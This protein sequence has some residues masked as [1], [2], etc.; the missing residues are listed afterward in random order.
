MSFLEPILRLLGAE[1][2]LF[3]L[4]RQYAIPLLILFPL[5]MF[6]M[7]FQISFITVGKAHLGFVVS[8]LGGITNIVLDYLLIAVFDMGV[9]GAAIATSIGYSIPSLSML[10]YTNV[11]K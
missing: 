5:S 4:S 7:V 11:I 1:G 10:K 3:N 8:V 6:G 2:D 9:A